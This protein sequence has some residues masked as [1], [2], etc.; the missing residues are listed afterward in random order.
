MM[1]ASTRRLL[2]L[3][4]GTLLCVRSVNASN[5]FKMRNWDWRCKAWSG[6]DLNGQEIKLPFR[7]NPEM[8]DAYT[9][10]EFGMEKSLY[11]T[12]IVDKMTSEARA[13]GAIKPDQKLCFRDGRNPVIVVEEFNGNDYKMW[14]KRNKSILRRLGDLQNVMYTIQSLTS[15]DAEN[16]DTIK[17]LQNRITVLEDMVHGKSGYKRSEASKNEKIK[18]L[19]CE[20][21]ELAMKV[22]AL[23]AENEALKE[24]L[25]KKVESS[26]RGRSRGSSTIRGQKRPR[27]GSAVS[28]PLLNTLAKQALD[29]YK[30][31]WGGVPATAQDLLQ[32]ARERGYTNVTLPACESVMGGMRML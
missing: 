17:V 14:F 28:A 23:E 20:R 4:V 16:A 5:T 11:R 8:I 25:A 7:L 9:N 22:K 24:K 1:K 12:R 10:P 2:I 3:G 15:K 21:D 18:S 30:K 26:R 13:Q 27:A 29:A 31:A 19:T 32:D 6:T